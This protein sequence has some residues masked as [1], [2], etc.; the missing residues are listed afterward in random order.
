MGLQGIGRIQLKNTDTDKIQSIQKKNE[1]LQLKIYK[2]LQ[3]HVLDG[4]SPRNKNNN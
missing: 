3:R 1:M 2:F 4:N